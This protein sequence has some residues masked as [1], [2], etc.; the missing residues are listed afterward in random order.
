[1]EGLIDGA[2]DGGIVFAVNGRREG[3]TAGDADANV[4]DDT[5]PMVGDC[6]GYIVG[7][8][9]EKIEVPTA[10]DRTIAFLV[11]DAFNSSEFF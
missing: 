10:T 11:S 6:E 4:V 9:G 8:K 1:M 2:S 7:I 3:K 5:G